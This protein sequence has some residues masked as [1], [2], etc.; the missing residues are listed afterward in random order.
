MSSSCDQ[1]FDDEA[2]P[3]K[4]WE[5]VDDYNLH[6]ATKSFINWLAKKP[7]IGKAAKW[8]MFEQLAL[9]YDMAVN[10]IEAHE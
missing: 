6:G 3:L 2:H 10:F 4:D 8:W 7:C 9:G 5:T 1:A